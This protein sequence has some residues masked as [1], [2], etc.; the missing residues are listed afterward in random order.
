M[1]SFD[2]RCSIVFTRRDYVLA[3]MIR[4]GMHVLDNAWAFL[5]TGFGVPFVSSHSSAVYL[6]S[7]SRTLS[8]S[9]ST[10]PLC[11]PSVGSPR[12]VSFLIL[13]FISKDRVLPSRFLRSNCRIRASNLLV[14]AL[15]PL[16]CMATVYTLPSRASRC[17][18]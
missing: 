1:I 6:N 15:A 17:C 18:H 5:I 7:F 9:P 3:G 8:P 2:S 14:A 4:R 13:T 12:G 10:L 16:V 11:Y